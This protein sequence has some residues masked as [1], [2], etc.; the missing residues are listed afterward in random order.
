MLARIAIPKEVD[1][2]LVCFNRKLAHDTSQLLRG[3]VLEQRD[4]EERGR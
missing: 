3:H 2:W 4:L 1:A